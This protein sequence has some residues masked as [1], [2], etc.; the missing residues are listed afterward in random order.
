[1]ALEDFVAEMGGLV[2][3]GRQPAGWISAGPGTVARQ[4]N[5]VDQTALAQQ[6]VPQVAPGALVEL[7]AGQLPLQEQLVEQGTIDAGGLTWR[8][9]RGRLADHV[10]DINVGVRDGTTLVVLLTSLANERDVLVR[11]VLQPALG[12]L[13]L[14]S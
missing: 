4:R 1:V 10:I 6:A 11:E 3:T 2:I 8:S 5:L 12:A 9:Y 13:R 7:L 14:E